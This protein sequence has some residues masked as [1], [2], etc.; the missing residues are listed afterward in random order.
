MVHEAGVRPASLVN[1]MRDQFGNYVV[2]V[3]ARPWAHFRPL[4][5]CLMHPLPRCLYV[6]PWSNWA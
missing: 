1:L 2:Q 3:G 6:C 4:H 5:G